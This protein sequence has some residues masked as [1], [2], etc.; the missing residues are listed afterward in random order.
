MF[1]SFSGKRY[2][3]AYITFEN[4]NAVNQV[5]YAE[6]HTVTGH[7]VTV[8]RLATPVSRRGGER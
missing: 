3:Y 4:D 2:G 5:M 6:P 1:F 8:R 7:Q